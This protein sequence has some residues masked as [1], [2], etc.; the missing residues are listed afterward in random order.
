[1]CVTGTAKKCSVPCRG[2][3]ENDR[4]GAER[5][6]TKKPEQFCQRQETEPQPVRQ[7]ARRWI[8]THHQLQSG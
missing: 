4:G 3:V 8:Q 5:K 7:P 1:M 2:E 6:N